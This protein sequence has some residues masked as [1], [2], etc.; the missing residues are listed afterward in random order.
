M[1]RK[2]RLLILTLILLSHAP[3]GP[4]QEAGAADAPSR[5][6]IAQELE[7]VLAATGSITD[8]LALVK[9]RAK[10]ANLLWLQD[11]ARAS[12]T[13]DELWLWVEGQG[14]AEF[15]QAARAEVLGNL[16]P[17]DA[18]AANALLEKSKADADGPDSWQV[19]E[20]AA[21]LLDSDP[22]TAARLLERSLSNDLMPP[23]MALLQQL[24]K[25]DAETAN[26]IAG[27]SL[28]SLNARPTADAA[29]VG[30]YTLIEYL[31]APG[32]PPASAPAGASDDALRRQYFQTSYAIL[33]RSLQP[34]EQ[35]PQNPAPGKG[36]DAVFLNL[37]RAQ[38]AGVLSALATRHAPERVSELG[39]LAARLS[40][41]LPPQLAEL[42]KYTVERANG[43]TYMPEE[44]TPAGRLSSAL[45]R[46]D[47][48]E[49]KR[50]L[51]RIEKE[52]VRKFYA[53][54][55]AVG[56]FKFHISRANLSGALDAARG[57]EDVRTRADMFA[58]LMRAALKKEDAALGKLM[59]AEA[60]ASLSD[61]GCG[62]GKAAAMFS[63]AAAAAPMSLGDSVELI[64]AGAACLNSSNVSAHGTERKAVA[65]PRG[66][67][68]ARDLQQAFST[69]GIIDLDNALLS[70]VKIEDR[71][72]ALLARLF[73]CEGALGAKGSKTKTVSAKVERP[74]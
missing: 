27:R 41:G 31:F 16:F 51:G 44:D 25:S 40:A 9:V 33:L 23:E 10:A 67:G 62:G 30:S 13:F 66:A 73:A 46:G 39:L 56:E 74:N 28:A 52:E 19:N 7:G 32:S 49:A 64:N 21:R 50:L 43:R 60:R 22:A 34:P 59:L 65:D 15:R 35:R 72:T 53:Y 2:A 48:D 45:A 70:A 36:A 17:R 63:L 37:C 61:A 42:A 47:F 24:R 29:L 20:L 8:R 68:D 6:R 69:L 4:A 14:D 3:A 18:G 26:R 11:S 57:V 54:Q 71:A 1:S 58:Q 5:Q 55:I 38:L 12:R